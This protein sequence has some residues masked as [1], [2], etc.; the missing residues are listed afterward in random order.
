MISK[1]EMQSGIQAAQTILEKISKASTLEEAKQTLKADIE[2]AKQNI[3]DAALPKAKEIVTLT[4]DLYQ[5]YTD[6]LQNYLE[7]FGSKQS[8][9]AFCREA[10]YQKTRNL[11]Q[12]LY[13]FAEKQGLN[14]Q[15]FYTKNSNVI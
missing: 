7:F 10:V 15:D 9:E 14:A 12:Q 5:P 4:I 3:K 8:L 11:A 1:Q 2:T 13:S 6:F